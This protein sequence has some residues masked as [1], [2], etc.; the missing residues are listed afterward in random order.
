M[1]LIDNA[2]AHFNTITNHRR[3]VRYYCF[4]AGLYYQGITHDLSK[5]SPTEFIVG[6]KYYQGDRS[7]NNAEREDK[8]LA[9]SQ[10][11]QQAS[12]GV[13]DRLLPGA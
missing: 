13:L 2:I 8:G 12:F 11:T 4:K 3:L 9:P 10:G 7:P 5:Y 6:V 1:K